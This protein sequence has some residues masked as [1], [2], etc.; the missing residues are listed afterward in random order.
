MSERCSTRETF[1]CLIPTEGEGLPGGLELDYARADG[2][3]C[4][5]TMIG[6]Q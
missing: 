5:A 2:S 3:P 4:G 1:S 6:Y